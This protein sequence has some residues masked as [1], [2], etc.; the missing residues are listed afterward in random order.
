M[1]EARVKVQ[2]SESGGLQVAGIS[3]WLFFVVVCLLVLFIFLMK[4]GDCLY[5]CYEKSTGEITSCP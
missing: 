2:K 4:V 5:F 1:F 3:Y